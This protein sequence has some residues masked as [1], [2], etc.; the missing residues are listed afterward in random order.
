M[1]VVTLENRNL[2]TIFNYEQHEVRTVIDENGEIWF[3]V[4]DVCKVLNI[5]DSNQ[6]TERLDEDERGW[7]SVRTPRGE[8]TMTCT[9]ESGLYELMFTSRKKEAKAFKRW[10]KQEVIPSIRKT[11]VYDPS[12]KLVELEQKVRTE[13]AR[14]DARI[15]D[16][17]EKTRAL[18]L[19]DTD[20]A[21]IPVNIYRLSHAITD[22]Q[23]LTKNARLQPGEVQEI[24]AQLTRLTRMMSEIKEALAHESQLH[25]S[26][27]DTYHTIDELMSDNT[28]KQIEE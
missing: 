25:E 22:L 5:K 7:Y 26:L 11:G 13:F 12:G 27:I 20:R 6:A 3:V 16:L 14:L 28:P 10:I 2:P 4:A 24:R 17:D 23:D 15:D 1:E 9:N 19:D 8:Q 18:H 21:I